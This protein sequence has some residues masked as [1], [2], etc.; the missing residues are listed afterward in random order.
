MTST[1]AGAWTLGP[2]AG[3]TTWNTSNGGVVSTRNGSLDGTTTS[4]SFSSPGGNE[5]TSNFIRTASAGVSVSSAISGYTR[6]RAIS[7]TSGSSTAFSIETNTANTG[8]SG[9]NVNGT[10]TNIVSVTAAGAWTFPIS[11]VTHTITGRIEQ[12]LGSWPTDTIG[13]STSRVAFTD[14]SEGAIIGFQK[15][16]VQAAD[17]G[18]SVFL[19]AAHDN[20]SLL[21]SGGQL[22]GGKENGAATNASGYMSFSTSNGSGTFTERGRVSSAGA[23]TL[24]VASTK[25]TILGTLSPGHSAPSA[26]SGTNQTITATQGGYMR[27]D[28]VAGSASVSNID[29]G[30]TSPS[31]THLIIYNNGAN[32]LTFVTGAATSGTAYKIISAV[33]TTVATATPA[34][35]VFDG[36]SDGWR[37]VY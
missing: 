13:K 6:I 17:T 21:M 27:L 36:I 23:W 22:K 29:L 37:R 18:Y 10:E 15:S 12:G 24:G 25:Q 1:G 7:V 2:A 20:S 34:G 5:L 16:S 30:V 33:S 19:G 35:F 11:G 31:G 8:V 32:T 14:T 26:I 28:S 4:G 3:V 9:A